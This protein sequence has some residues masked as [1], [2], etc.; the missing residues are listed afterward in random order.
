MHNDWRDPDGNLHVLYLDNWNG[1]RNLNTNIVDNRWNRSCRF[2]G[3]RPRNFL[4]FNAPLL[5]ERCF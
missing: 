4:H 3:R 2:P 5:T 1:K